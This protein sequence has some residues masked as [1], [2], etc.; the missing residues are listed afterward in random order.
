MK[1]ETVNSILLKFCKFM[2]F[3]FILALGFCLLFQLESRVAHGYTVTELTA[4]YQNGQVFLTWK[5]PADTNL[6]YNVYRSLSP[7]TTSSQIT[8][9]SYLGYVRD[10]SGRN[11]RKSQLSTQNQQYY[12]VITPNQSPLAS[13]R[14]LYVATCTSSNIYYYAV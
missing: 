11:L 4:L 14:G 8:A 3:N 6:Q 7:I 9:S 12:Y 5:N 13:D 1:F 10:N 2:R